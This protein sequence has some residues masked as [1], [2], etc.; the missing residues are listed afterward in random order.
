MEHLELELSIRAPADQQQLDVQHA[1]RQV[2]SG[3]KALRDSPI[4]Y[5]RAR[6][7]QVVKMLAR[8]AHD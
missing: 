3:R 5:P 1:R 7:L 4:P 2:L 6:D 8:L